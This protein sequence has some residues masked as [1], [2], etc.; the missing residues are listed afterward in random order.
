MYGKY[1]VLYH[2]IDV[3]MAVV[4]DALSEEDAITAALQLAPICY[5]EGSRPY[6]KAERMIVNHW[7][8]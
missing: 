3:V 2:C 5:Y 8:F 6:I 1:I 4:V 7:H